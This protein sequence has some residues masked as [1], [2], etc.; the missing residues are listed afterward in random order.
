MS[1][2]PALPRQQV[3]FRPPLRRRRRGMGSLGADC[4]TPILRSNYYGQPCE[5]GQGAATETCLARQDQLEQQFVA[6][7]QA[8]YAQCSPGSTIQAQQAWENQQ[9]ATYGTQ[10]YGTDAAQAQQQ[11]AQFTAALYT[12]PTVAPKITF[13]PPSPAPTPAAPVSS[14]ATTGTGT[15]TGA[16]GAPPASG[17]P[18][19]TS[20]TPVTAG[21]DLSGLLSGS[22]LGIPNLL[23]GI[24][25][26][27]GVMAFSGG[28]AR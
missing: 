11:A 9:M 8:W 10:V 19:P 13:A 14:P 18:A 17:S 26:V 25:V 28:H 2:A 23:L 27:I 6:D 1:Y 7:Q 4:S 21:F 12:A 20:G 3:I 5:L 16:A 24:G 22:T 15:G